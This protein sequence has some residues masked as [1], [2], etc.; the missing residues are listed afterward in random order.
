MLAL[1]NLIVKLY[2][3]LIWV[4]SFN[5]L[6]AKALVNGRK[7]LLSKIKS[8][9]KDH[10]PKVWFHFASLGEFEQGRTVIEHLKISHPEKKIIITFFSPSGYEVRKNYP[11]AEN[12]FYLP[13]DNR[14]NAREFIK[15]INP[16][17][18]IFTKYEYWYYYFKELKKN[19]IPLYII[20]GIFREN[21]IFFKWY[22]KIYREMLHCVTHFFVQN[23]KSVELLDSINIKNV[24]LSGD[25]R[26]DRVFENAQSVKEIPLVKDFCGGSSTLVAGST[27]PDDEKLLSE[28]H[29]ENQTWKFIIAPHEI[30]DEKLVALE[31]QFKDKTQR[32]SQ[33]PEKGLSDKSILIIDNIGML[34]A[35]YQYGDIAYIGGGFGAGIHN[36]LEAAA[37]GIPVI[38]G[39]KYQKFAEAKDLIELD[40]AFTIKI[41]DELKQVFN[42]LKD[43]SERIKSGLKAKE[44]IKSKIGATNI[45]LD[46]VFKPDN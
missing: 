44:Y 45:I 17:I 9:L 8:D 35:L 5:N 2:S 39:P 24:S 18:A 38:F 6:K 34:S 13:A 43:E 33:L 20:S 32:Y 27:W 46:Q 29:S 14:F 42:R 40:A 15:L 1:Y 26:F 28:L 22:G 25:T 3:F 7:N 21:Q 41:S 16:E 11:L 36:T 30:S 37:F 4:A 10:D 23:E 12:V 19:N 31:N